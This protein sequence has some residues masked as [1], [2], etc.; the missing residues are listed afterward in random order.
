MYKIGIIFLI[1][2]FNFSTTVFAAEQ[3]KERNER[4]FHTEIFEPGVKSLQVG[5]LNNKQAAP[6]I[7]LTQDEFVEINF[8]VLPFAAGWFSYRITHCNAD[9]TPSALMPFEYL[10]GFEHADIE[11]FANSNNSNIKYT[12]YRLLFPN[13]DAEFKISGNYVVSIYNE[14]TPDD[15]ALNVRFSVVDPQVDILAKVSNKIDPMNQYAAKQQLRFFVE[16]PNLDIDF[17]QMNVKASIYM[18]QRTDNAVENISP[19]RIKPNEIIF[20]DSTKLLFDAGNEYRKFTFANNKFM[21]AHIKSTQYVHPYFQIKLWTDYARKD[22][23]YKKTKDNNGY[24]SIFNIDVDDPD[25]EASYGYIYFNIASDSI[26]NAEV[27]LNGML[28]N[29]SLSERSQMMYNTKQACYEK[30]ILLKQGTYDYQYLIKSTLD[31]STN[32]LEITQNYI[33]GNFADT[34]NEYLILIYYRAN[35]TRYDQ[36]IGKKVIRR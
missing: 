8:D 23:M 7:T 3:Q 17:P 5:M 2:G 15:L 27:H 24:Y 29:N 1:F 35:G 6:V 31:N 10:D 34:E 36:L 18:N 9:W 12:N 21:G 13:E 11:D 20:Q 16:H 14:L 32:N 4:P 22:S 25:T 30:T 19:S 28:F 26:P 33:E